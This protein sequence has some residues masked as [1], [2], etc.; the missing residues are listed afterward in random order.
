MQ[1]E[2]RLS[3]TQAE[4]LERYYKENYE[5]L[6]RYAWRRLHDED[7]AR[8]AVQETFLVA[9]EKIEA[10]LDSENPTGWLVKTLQYTVNNAERE[11]AEHDRRTIALSDCDT[12]AG[13]Q[14]PEPQEL[15]FRDPDV[16]LLKTYYEDGY[17]PQELAEEMNTSVSALKMR[18]HR[19]KQRLSKKPMIQ[20]LRNL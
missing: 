9:A 14:M 3:P 10:F 17:S 4:A 6:F 16:A 7:R 11:Q 1:R 20:F 18:V 5:F 15:D 2:K 8:V 12:L 19:A 13:A